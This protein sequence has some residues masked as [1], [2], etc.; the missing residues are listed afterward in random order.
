MEG[1]V[2]IHHFYFTFWKKKYYM[3]VKL[4]KLFLDGAHNFLMKKV[5]KY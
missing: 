1:M 4:V 5:E 3:L 2:T